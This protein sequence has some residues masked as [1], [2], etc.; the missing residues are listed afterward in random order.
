MEGDGRLHA[1]FRGLALEAAMAGADATMRRGDLEI[2]SKEGPNDLVTN[3]DLASEAAVLDCLLLRRRP[4]DAVLA[5][6]SRERAGGSGVRWVIDPLDG[7][8]QAAR[9]MR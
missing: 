1:A 4:D 9:S 2:G 6:E 3:A 7:L 8:A 5:E